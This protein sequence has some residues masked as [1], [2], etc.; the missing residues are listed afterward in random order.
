MSQIIEGDFQSPYCIICGACG[1]DGCC[2]PI[3]CPQKGGDYCDY[4]LR[5]LKTTYEVLH[6]VYDDLPEELKQK[7]TDKVWEKMK[8]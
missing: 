5:L 6:E 8:E 1:E 3:K 4:Y 7:V 2:S